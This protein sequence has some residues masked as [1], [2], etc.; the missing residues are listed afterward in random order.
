LALATFA[1][2]ALAAFAA[3]IFVAAV[4]VT[5]VFVAAIFMSAIL[6]RQ[7]GGSERK[8]R[9]EPTKGQSKYPCCKKE[10]R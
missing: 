9:H 5:T 3:A 7:C 8:D 1:T 6:L 4:L 10:A 2:L